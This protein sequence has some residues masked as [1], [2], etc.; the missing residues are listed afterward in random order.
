M[1]LHVL[2]INMGFYRLVM[3]GRVVSVFVFRWSLGS[4]IDRP[5]IV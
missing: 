4:N 3:S 5:G 1:G 2:Y